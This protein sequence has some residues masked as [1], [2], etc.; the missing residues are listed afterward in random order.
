[1]T[2]PDSALLDVRDAFE[3]LIAAGSQGGERVPRALR[4]AAGIGVSQLV[5]G[6]VAG[7]LQALAV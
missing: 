6:T 1:V 2:A 4:V 3:D 7:S 5:L